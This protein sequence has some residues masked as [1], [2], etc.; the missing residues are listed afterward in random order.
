MRYSVV[1]IF[2]GVLVAFRR[3]QT[4]KASSGRQILI[5][6]YLTQR[7]KEACPGFFGG[8]NYDAYDQVDTDGPRAGEK[9]QLVRLYMTSLD[10]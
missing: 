9:Y 3:K 7:T 5:M 8:V 10:L 2:W 1:R 6:F 4:I